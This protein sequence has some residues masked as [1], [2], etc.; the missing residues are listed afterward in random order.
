MP[1]ISD[2]S[3]Y[4]RPG[5]EGV[6]EPTGWRR[7]THRL[8]VP[9]LVLAG[10]ALI[11]LVAVGFLHAVD[12]MGD[13]WQCSDGEA[14]AGNACYPLDQPLPPGIHWDPLGN[15]PMPYN[16][17]KDGWTQIERDGTDEQDCLDD[18]LPMPAGWHPVP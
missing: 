10:L 15:R 18:D 13:E 16:C 7:W 8:L 17:D 6:P 12:P 3:P 5:P 11:P 14:P 9:V 2:Q 1:P 4:P